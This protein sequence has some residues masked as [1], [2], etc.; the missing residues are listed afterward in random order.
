M[1][2][3]YKIFLVI[4]ALLVLSSCKDKK[5]KNPII[6]EPIIIEESDFYLVNNGTTEYTIVYPENSDE[7]VSR[8][9]VTELQSFFKQATGLELEAISDKDLSYQVG[10]KYISI[11][12]TK[13]LKTSGIEVNQTLGESGLQV[14]TKDESVFM[15]GKTKF[16]SLYSVYEFLEHQLNFRVYAVDE[17]RI[18]KEVSSLKLLKFNTTDIPTFEYRLGSYG[19][20]WYGTTFTR[21]MRMQTNNDIWISLGGLTY[22]NFFATVPPAQ[23]KDTNPEWYSKDGRQ[24]CLLTDLDGIKEVV[25]GQMK[26]YIKNN[27][28]ANNLTFTQEDFNVWC[29]NDISRALKEKYGTN[30]AEMIIFLNSVAEEIETWLAV[31]EPGREV[32]LVMFAYHKTEDAPARF[33]EALQKY[34]PIDDEV[35]LRD[36][37]AVLYAPIFS[38]HYYDYYH[39]SNV[40]TAE[41]MK[42]WGALSNNIYLWS[43]G[44]YFLNYLTPYDTFNS[45][46]GK[47]Q[48]AK[49]NNT[50]YV[51][52]QGQYNQSKGTDWYRLKE[53]LVAELQ[54]DVNQDMNTLIDEFFVNY[55]KDAAAPMMDYFKSYRAWYAYIAAEEGFTGYVT[56]TVLLQRNYFPQGILNEWMGYLNEAQEVIKPLEKTDPA[57]YKLLND[58]IL[59]ETISIRYLTIELYSIYYSTEENEMMLTTLKNDALRLGVVQFN[60]FNTLSDYFDKK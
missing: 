9:A 44:T 1:K 24:L 58:R 32:T 56:E 52:D 42:K 50:S 4:A 8:T 33:D 37:V 20:L 35:I 54:W 16:G 45:I 31:E 43:Y 18:D 34:V 25:V 23:Y 57:L 5:P 19:E 7:M 40:N 36:N 2:K 6:E 14:V 59:L 60:E 30:A 55:F 11:G 49:E 3:F 47:Y 27:P 39:E 21:R 29:E 28:Q 46:Q 41:T 48:F 10:Q 22:H 26:T 53:F 17:I 15:F 12:Q 51:F 13:L 38:E